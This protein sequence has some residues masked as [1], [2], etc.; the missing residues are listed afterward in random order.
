MVYECM[1]NLPRYKQWL[2]K[3]QNLTQ[4]SPEQSDSSLLNSQGIA[5]FVASLVVPDQCAR[6]PDRGVTKNGDHSVGTVHNF[7]PWKQQNNLSDAY[8]TEWD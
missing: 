7:T 6:C 4:I 8:Q 1:K 2:H 5:V 3:L